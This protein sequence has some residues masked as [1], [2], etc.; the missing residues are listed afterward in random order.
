QV[1]HTAGD[2]DRRLPVEIAGDDLDL[3]ERA[4]TRAGAGGRR[5]AD[6]QPLPG[7]SL[8][9]ALLDEHFAGAADRHPADARLPGHAMLGADAVAGPILAF[10]NRLT[11]L[12]RQDLIDRRAA[13]LLHCQAHANQYTS[14]MQAV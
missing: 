11:D 9:Q 2:L 10:E 7:A 8:Q 1:L 6:I 5:R 12:V 4:D 14:G 13:S 3:P